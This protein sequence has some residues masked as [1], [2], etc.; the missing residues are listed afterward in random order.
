V[1]TVV[2]SNIALSDWGRYLGDATLTAPILA[3]PGDARHPN[4]HQRT[5]LAPARRQ[6]RAVDRSAT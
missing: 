3:R 1:S 5:Q 2:T 4:R 6:D